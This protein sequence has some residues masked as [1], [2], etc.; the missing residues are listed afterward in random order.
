MDHAGVSHN[1]VGAVRWMTFVVGRAEGGRTPPYI[2]TC[3]LHHTKPQQGRETNPQLGIR[4]M[5]LI[6][7]ILQKYLLYY[8][9]CLS[10]IFAT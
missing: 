7:S 5:A 6:R 8:T 2:H 3:T 1:V 9:S 4:D 10:S